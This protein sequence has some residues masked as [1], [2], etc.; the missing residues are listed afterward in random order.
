MNKV[1][2]LGLAVVILLG[3][4]LMLWNSYNKAP[5]PVIESRATSTL[6][7]SA[8]KS[9]G[10]A[11]QNVTKLSFISSVPLSKVA[12]AHYGIENGVIHLLPQKGADVTGAGELMTLDEPLPDADIPTFE[13]FP[14]TVSRT[15]STSAGYFIRGGALFGNYAKDKNHVYF[16]ASIIAGADPDTFLLLTDSANH[17]T[18]YARDKSHIYVDDNVLSGVDQGTFTLVEDS[19]G[20]LAGGYL[21]WAKDA[22]HVYNGI[23]V[24]DAADADSF[25]SVNDSS[26]NWT[27]YAKDKLHVYTSDFIQGTSVVP[28]ADPASFVPK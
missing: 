18:G 20:A 7:T 13:V 5:S 9:A 1:V 27:G 22:N 8:S 4:G 14:D 15:G 23:Q 2:L 10:P 6:E 3:G 25:V 11:K 26:G 17:I 16:H 19:H 28:N 24:V 12:N 21:G